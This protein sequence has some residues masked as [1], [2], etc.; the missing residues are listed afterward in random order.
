M[1][2]SD[3]E[4]QKTER[5]LK[6]RQILLNVFG[7]A[8]IAVG[9]AGLALILWAVATKPSDEPSWVMAG[10][11]LIFT[12]VNVFLVAQNYHLA[13]ASWRRLALDETPT[14]AIGLLGVAEQPGATTAVEVVNNSAAP[15][16][17]LILEAWK[18]SPGGPPDGWQVAQPALRSL[19]REMRP[20]EAANVFLLPMG[21]KEDLANDLQEG[22]KAAH[23]LKNILG[24]LMPGMWVIS[25]KY[26]DALWRQQA[27][28]QGALSLPPQPPQMP[29]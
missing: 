14:I 7:L 10:N 23:E 15:A 6:R 24:Q 29:G 5:R 28:V 2:A 13:Q 8:V 21:P 3:T 17:L 1:S 19:P 11:A 12:A 16:H 25:V 27:I 9:L 4:K 20:Y 26:A 18:L 22:K